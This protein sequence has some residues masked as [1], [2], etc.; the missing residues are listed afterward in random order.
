MGRLGGRGSTTGPD[1]HRFKHW[2]R[3]QTQQRLSAEARR[4]AAQ[5]SPGGGRLPGEPSEVLTQVCLIVKTTFE[6]DLT[7][8]V[9]AR[10]HELSGEFHTPAHDVGMRRLSVG[11]PECPRE[12]RLAQI[13]E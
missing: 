13:D 7:Q 6:R 12:V 2:R 1:W 10:E 5:T 8:G 3:L 9:A 11:E 4:P